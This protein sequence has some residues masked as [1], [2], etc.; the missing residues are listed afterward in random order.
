MTIYGMSQS[1]GV[2][3]RLKVE[4]GAHGLVLTF[5]DHVGSKE[6][7]R[8]LVPVDDLLAAI[9]E[10]HADGCTIEGI[11]PPHGPKMLLG[12]EVRRNEVLLKVSAGSGDGSDVAV[13]LDDF[14]DA[15][16]KV[17]SRA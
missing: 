7:E 1:T 16:E 6:R 3:R 11:L 12:V 10:A 4:M 15:V 14:Q 2:E 9:T 8:I 5:I 13:G 17:V